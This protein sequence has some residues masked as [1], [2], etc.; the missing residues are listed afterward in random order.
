MNALFD[1]DRHASGK[2][3]FAEDFDLAPG[4]SPSPTRR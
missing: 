1:F 3:L 2:V 4:L